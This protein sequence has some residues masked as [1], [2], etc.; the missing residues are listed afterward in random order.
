[1]ITVTTNIY[2]YLLVELS[3]LSFKAREARESEYLCTSYLVKFSIESMKLDALLGLV[4]LMR[5]AFVSSCLM[6]IQRRRSHLSDSVWNNT[7]QKDRNE[8]LTYKRLCSDIN[9]RTIFCQ[10]GLFIDATKFS[11][12]VTVIANLTFNQGPSWTRKRE[13]LPLLSRSFGRCCDVFVCRS[14]Y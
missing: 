12:V 7:K 8:N 3:W 2:I 10:T 6:N 14:T 11:S 5:L 4:G 1:M 13:C 9:L